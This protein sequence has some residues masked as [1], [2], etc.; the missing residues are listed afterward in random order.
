M[1]N[2][3][4]EQATGTRRRGTL[5]L[6]EKSGTNGGGASTK[7]RIRRRLLREKKIETS[8]GAS[9]E[10]KRPGNPSASAEMKTEHG[11]G[12][13]PWRGAARLRGTEQP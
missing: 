1:G 3:K 10:S 11:D 2:R 9:G 13:E 12:A 4:E 8:G 6:G 7:N 5:A